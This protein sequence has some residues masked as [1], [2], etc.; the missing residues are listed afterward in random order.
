MS[1]AI[2]GNAKSTYQ[3]QWAQTIDL[4]IPTEGIIKYTAQ[5]NN[6]WTENYINI[7]ISFATKHIAR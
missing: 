1:M 2:S 5:T 6:T 3:Y 4:I 7:I